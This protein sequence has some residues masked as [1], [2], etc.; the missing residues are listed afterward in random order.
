[1]AT[2]PTPDRG[3]PLDLSYI[4][5]ITEA[6]NNLSK[7]L[8]PTTAKYTIIKTDSGDQTTR[9]SDSRIIGTYV[10]VTNGTPTTS[11]TEVP[12]SYNF[13]DFKYV[14]IITAT[15]IITDASNTDASKDISVVLTGITTSNVEGVVKFNTI[16]VSS[17]SVNLIIVG[18]PV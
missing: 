17:V 1:M 6:V 14:P 3:Q 4:Y 10:S 2:L 8:S 9:T 16:G 7:Q 18:I 5:Q 12:F 11:G 15:P 13:S